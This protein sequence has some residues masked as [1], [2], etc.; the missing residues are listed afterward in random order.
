V[1]LKNMRLKAIGALSA[2]ELLVLLHKKST[3]GEDLGVRN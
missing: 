2:V 1:S 3:M